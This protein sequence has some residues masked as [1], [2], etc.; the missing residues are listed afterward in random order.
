DN[1]SLTFFNFHTGE[2][3]QNYF[4]TVNPGLRLGDTANSIA[5]S[6]NRGY[7]VMNGSNTL[8][9]IEV[10]TAKSL[11]RVILRG[12][13]SPRN[14]VILNDTLGFVTALFTDEVIRFNPSTLQ[15]TGR[16]AVGP[17]PEGIVVSGNRLFVANSGLGD[18][19]AGEPGAGTV[20]VVDIETGREMAR[21]PVLPNC[22]L[23]KKSP[24]GFL[25]VSGT[26]SYTNAAVTGLAILDPAGLR[27]I[28]TL[29]VGGHPTDFVLGRSG[30][31]YVL[32]DSAVVKFNWRARQVVDAHFI[33]KEKL[34]QPAWFSAI[35]LAESRKELYIGNA[36]NF[37][38]NGEVI[39]FDFDGNEKFRFPTKLNPGTLYFK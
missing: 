37:T 14:A 13:P 20:S 27:V 26:G 2:V 16:I 9:V 4:Q 15:E 11:G 30:L 25:F 6:G 24:E 34:G 21:V 7:I 18:I 28:D 29:R 19:R 3:F 12:N 33:P 23:I 17:A 1:A 22:T 38:T 5:I 10:S 35:A 32:T 39:C 36:R 31:G 8:E